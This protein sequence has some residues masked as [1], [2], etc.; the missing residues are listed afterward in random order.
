MVEELTR[1]D[2]HA[3]ARADEYGRWRNKVVEELGAVEG[4]ERR[5]PSAG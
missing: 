4:A 2:L 1:H 3:L 5:G